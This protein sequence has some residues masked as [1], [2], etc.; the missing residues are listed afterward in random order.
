[1]LK[2]LAIFLF[3]STVVLNPGQKNKRSDFPQSNADNQPAQ[4]P[5]FVN[6]V[7]EP[8]PNKKTADAEP[9]YWYASP[10]WWLCI[11]GVP[12]LFFIGLQA[13]ETRKAAEAT[14]DSIRL[15][16]AEMV[17]TINK[18]RPYLV[19]TA[20]SAEPNE[21]VLRAKNEGNTPAR[22]ASVWHCPIVTKRT[23]S[24]KVPTEEKTRESLIP[25]LPM[26]LPPQATFTVLK[27]GVTEM[28]GVSLPPISSLHFY[29]RIRYF[30]TL[31]SEQADAYETRLLY[32]AIPVGDRLP[33]PDPLHPEHNTWT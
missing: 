23:E 31:E 28:K 14:R 8:S 12:T 29:A 18:E 3:A 20:E 5:L 24:L 15:Q 32:W 10:E 19:V 33:I 2:W 21:F 25:H 11:L 1:M 6:Q 27:W 17:V 22:I 4:A 26:L 16:Q 9:P 7:S 13:K 30:N